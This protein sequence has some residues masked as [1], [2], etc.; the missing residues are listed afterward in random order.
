[1]LIKRLLKKSVAWTTILAV[2]LTLAWPAGIVLG[3]TEISRTKEPVAEGVTVETINLQTEEGP[4]NIYVMTIDLSNQYVK[5]DTM[6]GVNGIITKNQTV[7]NMAKETGAVGA[8]NG[9]FFQMKEDAPIGITVKSG[10]LVTSPAQTNSMYGFGLTKD[11]RP[12]FTLFGFQGTVTAPSGLQYQLF[13]INKPTYLTAKD[14]NSDANRLN[15]YTPSW[16]PNSR[17]SLPGLTG[18]VEMVVE[19]DLVKEIRPGQPGTQI[20]QNGYVL[21]GH[22]TA[23]QY[24]TANFKTG[25]SVQVSYQVSPENDNLSAAIGGQALLVQDGQRHWFSNN[26]TGNYA[27]SAIGASQDGKTLYLVVVDGGSSSAGMTQEE[28][29]DYMVSIGAWTALNFDGGGSSTMVARHLGDQSVSLINNPVYSSQRS[30]PTGIGVF[31]SAPQGNFAGLKVSGPKYVLVETKKGYSAKGYDEHY[32]P[33]SV[34]PDDL[35]WE[36]SP[37]L[38]TFQG[39]IFT[40]KQSGDGIVKASYSGK[41]QEYPVKVLG[42]NDI[43]K[44]EVT[45]ASIAVNPGDAVTLS[46]KITTKQGAVFVLQPDEY[47]LQVKGDVGTVD[48]NKFTAADHTA[49]GEL[50]A[51]ID[52]TSA[53]VKVSVGGT[54]KPFYGF[55]NAKV[56]NFRGYPVNESLGSFRLTK[57]S[58]PTFRGVGA[59]RLEY[60]FTKTAQTRAAYGNFDGGL[61]LPGQPLGLGLWALGDEGNGHWLRARITDAKGTEKLLDF[62]QDVNWKGWKHIKANIPADVKLPVTLTDIYLVETDGGSQDKGVIYFDELSVIG[63]PTAEELGKQPPEALTAQKDVLPATPVSLKLGSDLDLSFNN[64]AKSA[65]YS[66]TARQV[67]DTD[68]PTP[69]YNPVMPLYDIT[70]M[71]NGDDAK[72]LPGLMKIQFKVPDATSV[73]KARILLWDEVK[74]GWQQIPGRVDKETGTITVKTKHLGLFALAEDARPIPVFTDTG[75]SWAKDLISDMAANKI[76]SGYPDGRFLPTK[77]V[78]RA[79]FVTLLAN[80]LGWGAETTGV[81]FKDAIPAWAQ[82]SIAAAVNHGVVKGYDD[83]TFKPEKAI[84][85]AEMAV[86]IDKALG[87]INSS[88]SSKYSDAKAIQ[89]WAVQSVRN[90]KV[91]GVMQGSNNRFRPK[92]IANR[93]EATAVMAKILDFYLQAQ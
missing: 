67:W 87:L 36:I 82:G 23:G 85:R 7:G 2:L 16:G 13:G 57:A 43:S 76:V 52:S 32:N 84:N 93:G 31:S 15:M 79:E 46:V 65:T 48:G 14:T 34:S 45:P 28:L 89:P 44:V 66:I 27:R 74:Y 20:P 92:D 6:V 17:G 53:S 10:E 60:D 21:A 54:E 39:S 38:G 29:A 30:I 61:T 1:L 24:L 90:T 8:I 50:V 51:K 40:A 35:S 91:A 49:V 64:P 47:E 19:N 5:V 80:T 68:L 77:G 78:T 81:R 12:I 71:A 25:D 33:Y 55:E 83:G 58:E 59:A 26:I 75:S 4:Q 72:L 88:Q 11:S 18:M 62:A 42:S 69:G 3:Q 9:D 86:M 73:N 41:T 63:I 70:G 37:D 22:G 56:M